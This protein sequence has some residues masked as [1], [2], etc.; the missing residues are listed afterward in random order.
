[1]SYREDMVEKTVKP[2]TGLS[3]NREP[4]GLIPKPIREGGVADRREVGEGFWLFV[5]RRW[6]KV[7]QQ[8]W[9]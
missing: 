5:W 2:T 3:M 9:Q 1:M 4:R 8:N 6:V 7:W